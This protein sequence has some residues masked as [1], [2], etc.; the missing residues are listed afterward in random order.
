MSRNG[1]SIDAFEGNNIII[2][3][4]TSLS[5]L[6]FFTY[7]YFLDIAVSNVDFFNSFP[8]SAIKKG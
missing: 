4:R 1:K 2:I 7:F 8:Q 3:D 5:H 6:H